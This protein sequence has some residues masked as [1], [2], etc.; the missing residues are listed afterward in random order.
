MFTKALAPS[1]SPRTR[2]KGFHYFSTGRVIDVSGAEWVANAIV[3]GTRDYRVDLVRDRQRFTGACECPYYADR[4]EICKH[5]WAAMLEAEERGLLSGDGPVG[6]DAVLEPEYRPSAADLHHEVAVS[7]SPPG[8]R[9]PVAKAPAWQRFLRELQQDVAAAESAVPLPRFS[10]GEIVYAIDVRETLAGRGT[11]VTVFFRQ[12]RKN[13]AWTKPKPVGITPAEAEHMVDRDDRE[14]LSLLI[15]ASNG[16]YQGAPYEAG[17][18]RLSRY[19]LNG[20]LEDRV[21]PMV[22]RT[23]R[24]HLDG[25]GEEQALLPISWDVGPPWKFE[26]EI[27]SDEKDETILV[28]GAFFRE[29]E[30]MPLREPVLLLS[31]GFLFTRTSMAR[32]DLEGGFAWLARLRSFGRTAIPRAEAG[33]LLE[34]LARSGLDPRSLPSDLHY[35]VVEGAPRPRIR[36]GR[37]ERQNPYAVRQDLRA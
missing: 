9:T 11:V 19:V 6:D 31:R 12:R 22:A 36:V 7:Y 35:D 17:Y 2:A 34:T 27:A 18:P 32:L 29:G 20:P 28:D 25:V 16:W 10:N 23:G 13:G 5:I 15:G 21:L 30:R 14:I 24:A 37:P 8:A 1:V 3:R 26:L 4:A 33:A